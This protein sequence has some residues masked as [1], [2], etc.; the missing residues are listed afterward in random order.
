MRHFNEKNIRI[1]SNQ[2]PL[3]QRPLNNKIIINGFSLEYM[4]HKMKSGC[5]LTQEEAYLH[6][7]VKK[8]MEESKI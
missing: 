1:L 2:I 3:M 4:F 7:I 6:E 5:E 8:I